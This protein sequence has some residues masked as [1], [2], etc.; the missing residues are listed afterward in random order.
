M[1]ILSHLQFFGKP[2]FLD[3]LLFTKHLSI[4]LKSG[5]TIADALD[6]L[7]QQTKSQTFKNIL[8]KVLKNVNNGTS[9]AD[10]LNRFPDT[11]DHFYTSLIELGEES[12]TLE[13]NLAF[14]SEQLAKEYS[15]RK[16][17]QGALMYPAIVFVT[18]IVV[19]FSMSIFVL[20]KLVDLF[21]ALDVTLPLTTRILLFVANLMKYHGFLVFGI[22]FGL[23]SLFRLL[24]SLPSIKPYWHRFLLSLPIVGPFIQNAQLAL[25][26]RNLGVMLKSGLPIRKAL[27][28]QYAITTNL[29][30][31]KYVDEIKQA[32]NKGKDIEQELATGEFS[33]ISPIATKMIG[34]GE[35]TGKLDEVLLYLGDFFDDEVDNAA[36]NLSVVLEPIIL[37]VIGLVVGF[38]ALAIISPIYQ[39]TGSIHR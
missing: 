12:G 6:T 7:R 31:K 32:V 33:R 16:K 20:P 23:I 8:S 19:G 13:Q 28:V 2:S 3:K 10:A 4:M 11:F 18:I 15:L 27:D 22:F 30:F 5:I 36:K 26:C 38:V 14:L 1:Q 34:V 29:V 24:I 39:L 25:L 17:I 37:L 35:T 21:T 9:L